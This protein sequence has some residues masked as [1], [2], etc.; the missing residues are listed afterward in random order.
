M[1]DW[2]LKNLQPVEHKCGLPELP[3]SAGVIPE[4]VH[5]SLDDRPQ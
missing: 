5:V 2:R 3:I 4:S 1:S